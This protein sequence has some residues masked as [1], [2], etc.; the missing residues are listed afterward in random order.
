LK[1]ASTVKYWR[2]LRQNEAQKNEYHLLN[3]NVHL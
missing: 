3:A 2:D 1:A